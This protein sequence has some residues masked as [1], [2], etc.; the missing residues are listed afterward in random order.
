MP[1]SKIVLVIVLVMYEL[2]GPEN[3]AP[4]HQGYQ[5]YTATFLTEQR[6]LMHSGV[7]CDPTSGKGIGSLLLH[8]V[9]FITF[10][11]KISG[12][13]TIMTALSHARPSSSPTIIHS[14]DSTKSIRLRKHR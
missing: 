10:S 5:N 11:P 6:G 13:V 3:T 7:L 1:V 9:H 14:L 2:T 12:T 4:Q 8:F